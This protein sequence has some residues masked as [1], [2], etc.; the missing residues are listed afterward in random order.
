MKQIKKRQ[1]I[2][3]LELF[4]VW[5]CLVG[6]PEMSIDQISDIF[7]TIGSYFVVQ[8]TEH[9]PCSRRGSHR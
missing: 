4:K 9:T 1:P 5:Y 8:N 7:I 6:D 3:C 2:G